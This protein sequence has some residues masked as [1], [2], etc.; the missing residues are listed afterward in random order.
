MKRVVRKIGV[1]LFWIVLWQIAAM[2]IHQDLL[3]ASPIAAGKRLLQEMV[4]LNFWQIAGMSFGRISLGFLTGLLLGIVSAVLCEKSKVIGALAEPF[5]NF[6]KAVPVVCFVVLFLIWWGASFLSV[7]VSFLM[8]FPAVFFST[9]EGLRAVDYRQRE[10]ADVFDLPRLSRIFYLYRPALKPFFLGNVRTAVGLAWKSGVAAEVI[11]LAS[12]SIGEKIYLSKVYFDTAGVFAWTI[13]VV[14][15]SVCFETLVMALLKLFFSWE[16]ALAAPVRK[17]E[18]GAG[19]IVEKLSKSYDGQKVLENCS[20]EVPKGG[21]R[22]LNWPSGAGKTTLLRILLGLEEPDRS[23]ICSYGGAPCVLFQEDRLC[24][25]YSPIINVTL[26]NGSKEKAEEILSD[27][28]DKE[29]LEKPCETLS[30]GERRRVALARALAAQGS[31]LLLDEP[32]AGLDRDTIQRAWKVILKHQGQR[33]LLIASHI[34]P[35]GIP[36]EQ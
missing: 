10:M 1:L 16:Y 35:E 4:S 17:T 32:F 28:L 18:K 12:F 14:A 25:D 7:A 27:L 9:L 5:V 33:T 21:T 8:V 11:G 36:V 22:W 26:V 6:V 13:V 20:L 23:S 29:L 3:F 2:L 24:M 15:L 19:I 34:L 30:G 31:V